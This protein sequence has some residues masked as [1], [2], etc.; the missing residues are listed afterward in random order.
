[1][2]PSRHGHNWDQLVRQQDRGSS[3]FGIL[4]AEDFAACNQPMFQYPVERSAKKFLMPLRTIAGRQADDALVGA[5]SN[6]VGKD[7]I[8]VAGKGDAREMEHSSA[9][10]ACKRRKTKEREE[11]H[12]VCNHGHENR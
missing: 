5:R 8:I 3:A 1:M 4:K 2:R 10:Q 11:A 6:P 9:R 12:R 7:A